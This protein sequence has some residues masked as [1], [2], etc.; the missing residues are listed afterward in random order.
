MHLQVRQT[1]FFFGFEDPK[2][3]ISGISSF[4]AQ[5]EYSKTA[6]LAFKI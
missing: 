1:Y 2:P 5:S 3:N 6:I 4:V